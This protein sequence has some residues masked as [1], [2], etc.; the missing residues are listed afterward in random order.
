MCTHK[1]NKHT[2]REIGRRMLGRWAYIHALA[3]RGRERCN[4]RDRERGREI[5][6]K[7]GRERGR[8]R[9][10]GDEFE[11]GNFRRIYK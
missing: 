5:G 1:K 3:E 11:N 10:R 4:E 7:R 8:E 9:E 2:N 6:G